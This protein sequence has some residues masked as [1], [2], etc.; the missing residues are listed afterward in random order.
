MLSGVAHPVHTTWAG[1]HPGFG[2]EHS[3][4]EATEGLGAYT[5]VAPADFQGPDSGDH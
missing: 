5:R 2:P 1:D 3:G 4:A